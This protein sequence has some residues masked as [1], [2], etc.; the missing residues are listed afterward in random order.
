MNSESNDTSENILQDID[1]YVNLI[2][3]KLTEYK[4]KLE[5]HYKMNLEKVNEKMAIIDK[6][7]N[8][9]KN[10]VSNLKN[11]KTSLIK[12]RNDL[13]KQ[14][15]NYKK[16]L[17]NIKNKKKKKLGKTAISKRIIKRIESLN[18]QIKNITKEIN[19]NKK[20][21]KTLKSD[22][23]VIQ[24]K[25]INKK[26]MERRSELKQ[27]IN[28]YDDIINLKSFGRT[29]CKIGYGMNPKTKRCVKL[30]GKVGKKL[31]AEGLI[32]VCEKDKIYNPSTNNCVKRSGRQGKK[33]LKRIGVKDD[34]SFLDEYYKTQ[35]RLL[36][37]I[38]ERVKRVEL[39]L[40]ECRT[41]NRN[42]NQDIMNLR[43]EKQNIDLKYKEK[44]KQI[45]EQLTLN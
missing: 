16:Q 3:V 31:I 5:A 40:D 13:A 42:L 22:E 37:E 45:T 8:F 14:L 18:I 21:I 36:G 23:Q 27:E 17:D 35:E 44:N 30:T 24:I 29:H 15:E 4:E 41:I 2:N 11:D 39:T 19:D 28:L 25:N 20:K 12:I 38:N 6:E 9:Y 32:A 1:N 10:Q 7:K 34:K 43:I 33:I 26:L